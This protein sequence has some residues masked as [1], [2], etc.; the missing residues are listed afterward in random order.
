MADYTFV[1]IDPGSGSGAIVYIWSDQVHNFRI[2]KGTPKDIFRF[3]SDAKNNSL[4]VIA[5]FESVHAMPGQ[6]VS[7]TFSFGVNVG[8]IEMALLANDI[9]YK[10][11]T[12]MTWM[13]HFGMKKDKAESKPEWKN[14]LRQK[15]E[16]IMPSFNGT[17]DLVDS[18][19]IAIY[20]KDTY[21]D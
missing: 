11:I 20:C 8:H 7:S 3:L 6:G 1:G 16:E 15:L 17:N 4:N 14:R 12:P 9:P 5:Y 21:T 19:L 2:S 13:K 18:T 10:K